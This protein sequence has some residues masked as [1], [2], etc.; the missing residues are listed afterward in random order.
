MSLPLIIGRRSPQEHYNKQDGREEETP[1][2]V[3]YPQL[4]PVLHETDSTFCEGNVGHELA[5]GK[6]KG[7]SFQS[8]DK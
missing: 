5:S 8:I 1:E 7:P 2:S 4:P 6:K 3:V